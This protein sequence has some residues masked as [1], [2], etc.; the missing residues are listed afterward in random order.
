MLILQTHTIL[1]DDASW[2]LYFDEELNTEIF[3]TVNPVQ[4][5]GDYAN[6]TVAVARDLYDDD[7][8]YGNVYVLDNNN[9]IFVGNVQFEDVP[10]DLNRLIHAYDEHDIAENSFLFMFRAIPVFGNIPSLAIGVTHLPMT[11]LARANAQSLNVTRS[12]NNARDRRAQEMR[13]E[14]VEGLTHLYLA[15]YGYTPYYTFRRLDGQLLVS[16]AGIA[17]GHFHRP[18]PYARLIGQHAYTLPGFIIIDH[19]RVHGLNDRGVRTATSADEVRWGIST[20]LTISELHDFANLAFQEIGVKHEVVFFSE[21]NYCPH[22]SVYYG[23]D[24]VGF[25]G[26][27]LV[28]EEFFRDAKDNL[29]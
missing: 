22:E 12:T 21:N 18:S 25:G 23:L 10:F 27:S 6:V 29:Y 1:P 3:M 26:Y 24:V 20:E 5:F 11:A 13:R 14:W 4:D 28:G 2:W 8:L 9:W 7:G 19:V 17:A 15:L 16:G